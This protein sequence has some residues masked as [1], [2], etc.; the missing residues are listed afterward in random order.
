MKIK[1]FPTTCGEKISLAILFS[2]SLL[3]IIFGWQKIRLSYNYARILNHTF[4]HVQPLGTHYFACFNSGSKFFGPL[5]VEVC[6]EEGAIV[7]DLQS[8]EAITEKA[9]ND[10]PAYMAQNYPSIPLG[11]VGRNSL[12]LV[13]FNHE[14]WGKLNRVTS[15]SYQYGE[16]E[17]YGAYWVIISSRYIFLPAGDL[18]AMQNT[19]RHEL[20]HHLAAVYGVENRL[21]TA[22]SVPGSNEPLLVDRYNDA[23]RFE[24]FFNPR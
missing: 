24:Y 12:T 15:E 4:R 8:V 21:P 3:L 9:I 11:E 14:S 20:F 10:F 18:A 13:F 23:Y 5:K 6:V 22:S 16:A 17:C 19:L 1:I 2:L 7:T